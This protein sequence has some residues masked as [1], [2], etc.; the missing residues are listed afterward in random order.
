M[1]R[2]STLIEELPDNNILRDLNDLD[3]QASD[4]TVEIS[5]P[6]KLTSS[7]KEKLISI[8]ID[9]S[10]VAVLYLVFTNTH[11][12]NFLFS[13]QILQNYNG[14]IIGNSIVA[15]IVAIVYFLIKYFLI[16]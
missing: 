2:V 8:G 13:P 7:V 9:S 11:V 1:G 10:I 3:S 16:N 15:I 5:K 12:I 4:D 14:G 6:L